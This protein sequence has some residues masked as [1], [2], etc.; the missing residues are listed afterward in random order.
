MQQENFKPD[1]SPLPELIEQFHASLLQRGRSSNTARVYTSDIKLFAQFIETHQFKKMQ[2]A[3]EAWLTDSKKTLASRTVLR[4]AASL[5]SFTKFAELEVCLEDYKLPPTPPPDPH[6]LPGMMEDVEKMLAVSRN[7]YQRGLVAFGGLAGLRV[8]ESISV[9]PDWINLHER[10]LRVHGKGD[11]TRVVPI[12]KRLWSVMMPLYV[13]AK[14]DN[15]VLI[16]FEDRNARQLITGIAVRAGIKD[17]SSHDLRATFA[18]LLLRRGVDIRTI[19][20]LLGHASVSTTQ[21]YLGVDN[22]KARE[23]VEFDED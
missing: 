9:K 12:S 18:T 19:Q 23:A 8:S 1:R 5:N 11:K 3:A 16:P 17:V 6:P 10:K 7:P 15:S 13:S 14:A 2:D 21:A 22:K 20:Y 4:R